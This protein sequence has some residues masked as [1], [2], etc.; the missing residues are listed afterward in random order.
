MDYRKNRLSRL[1]LNG[2]INNGIYDLGELEMK[3]R[4]KETGE[5]VELV[6]EIKRSDDRYFTL[7]SYDTL[8][9]LCEAFDDYEEPKYFWY[10]CDFRVMRGIEGKFST[11]DI[12]AFTREEIAKLKAIGNYFETEE[13]AEKA[14]EKLKAWTR[15]ENKGAMFKGWLWDKCYGT[16]IIIG[17]GERD[18]IDDGDE[19]LDLL[20]SGGEE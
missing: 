11:P 4:I 3:L 8:A 7:D 1:G 2:D 5:I 14:V 10:I 6:G 17:Y 15:L 9:Q 20:F 13:E 19:D 18:Y 12:A 16:C